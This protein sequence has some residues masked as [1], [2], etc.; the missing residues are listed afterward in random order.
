M[1]LKLMGLLAALSILASCGSSHKASSSSSNAAYNIPTGLQSS[2]SAQYPGATHVIWSPYDVNT[3]PID[4]DLTDWTVLTPKDYTATFDMN[5]N[6][7]YAWY[8][9]NGNWVGS[10]YVM[11]NNGLPSS[12]N[13]TI[14]SR[15]SGY[16]VDKV[17]RVM[18]KDRTAYEV[19]LKNGNS[20]AK[21]L[22]DEN[23]NIIKE[24]K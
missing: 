14:S 8:D 19:K 13:N 9:A 11:S 15:Y 5:G 6:R 18:W 4:W 24:I 17:N 22:I 16:T 1:K 21:V 10:T 7:Y 20:K 2:F 12:L 23:G 3:S